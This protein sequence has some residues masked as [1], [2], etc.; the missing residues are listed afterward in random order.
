M[1]LLRFSSSFL[2]SKVARRIFLLFI[3]CIILPFLI[4]A[5]IT[6]NSVSSQLYEQAQKKL[7]RTAKNKGFEIY[8]NLSLLE[9]ELKIIAI[10]FKN[11]LPLIFAID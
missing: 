8:N 7:K 1:K 5:I 2:T 6:N 9:N 4:I 10:K 3:F 11:F